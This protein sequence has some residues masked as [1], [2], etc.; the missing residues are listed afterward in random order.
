MRRTCVGLV[1]VTAAFL[2]AT[3]AFAGPTGQYVLTAG[4]QKTDW[5]VQGAGVAATWATTNSEYPLIVLGTVRATG[6]GPGGVGGGYTL[7]GT[8]TGATYTNG[9]GSEM[10]DG[11]TDGSNIYVINWNTGNVTRLDLTWSNP[12]VL[13]SPGG[14]GNYLGITYDPTNNSLWV[15]GW[16]TG[17]VANYSLTGTLLSS[18]TVPYTA[19]TCLAMDYNDN[20]LW[21]GSQNTKGTF[22]QYSRTGTALS[23]QAYP[24]LASQNTLGGEF[25]YQASPAENVPALGTAGVAALVL[26]VGALGLLAVAR[27]RT[28]V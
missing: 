20:T 24:A 23:T 17:T 16:T 21:F 8:P 10:W 25:P 26:L 3:S 7:T 18:F 5:V 22:Y 28:V 11:A 19:L 1:I 12:Q 15:A 9:L 2:A 13:F 6:A 27:M 14:A 4:D